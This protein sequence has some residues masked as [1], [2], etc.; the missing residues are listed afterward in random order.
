[1]KKESKNVVL[2][3][4]DSLRADHLSCYGYTRNTS[5]NLDSLAKKGVLFLQAIS[6]GGGTPE[7]FPSILASTYPYPYGNVHVDYRNI[8][9]NTVTI[10]DVLKEN[11]YRTAAFHSNP[12]LSRLYG[13]DRGFNTFEDNLR[14][15]PT[16]FKEIINRK[17]RYILGRNGKLF[18]FL[19]EIIR[20]YVA[21]RKPP[22]RADKINWKAISWVRSHP[23]KFFIW[24]HYMDVHYPY[25]PPKEYLSKLH[26]RPI[27]KLEMFRLQKKIFSQADLSE[28]ELETLINLYDAEIRYVDDNIKLFLDKLEEMSI[29]SNTII[30][31]TADHGNE[32]GEHERFGFWTL[33]DNVI[34]VPLII[35]GPK[36]GENI[37]V[38]DQVSLL[39]IAPTIIDLSGLQKIEN[40]RG[41]SLLPMVKGEKQTSK[42]V[43]S[44][45]I[46][47]ASIFPTK[48]RIISYRT[49]NWK[50]IHTILYDGGNVKRE[51][52]DL[53]SDPGERKNIIEK[54]AEKAKE[55]ESKVLRHI[56]MVQK[57][58]MLVDETIR[59]IRELKTLSKI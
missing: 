4:I 19:G 40:F 22:L 48:D 59:K 41:E 56:L 13:Y 36:I 26:L 28:V 24:L 15:T 44:V 18:N 1:M 27:S 49:E 5:P 21:S 2:I 42:A 52:Y 31:V 45:S 55:L 8:L 53:R 43:I 54:E 58:E 17:I 35:N 23:Y 14:G 11:G 10:A 16:F 30:V 39:H 3:T 12:F 25:M 47:P 57:E 29:L 7:A 50:Y 51:L 38:K 34:H 9:K 33:Y 20:S 6:N 37:V 46:H 32:F